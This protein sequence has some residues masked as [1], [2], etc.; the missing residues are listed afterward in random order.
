M[1]KFVKTLLLAALLAGTCD[2]IGASVYYM[3]AGGKD[4]MRIWKFVASAVFGKTAYEGGTQMILIGLLFHYC[5]AFCFTLLFFLLYPRL[6]ILSNN[7][8]VAALIY[9]PFVHLVMNFLVLPLTNL[10]TRHFHLKAACIDAGILIFTIGLPVSL[11]AN[12]YYNYSK[13]PKIGG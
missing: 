11:M 12:Y 10:P 3:I 8:W 4:P 5:V 1:S 2:A 6:G 9:G 13:K 7:K